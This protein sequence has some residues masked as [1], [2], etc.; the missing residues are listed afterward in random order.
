MKNKTLQ[1]N[2]RMVMIMEE[3]FGD[4][5]KDKNRIQNLMKAFEIRGNRLG[6]CIRVVLIV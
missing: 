6:R 5:Y 3:K 2:R 1:K 4:Y